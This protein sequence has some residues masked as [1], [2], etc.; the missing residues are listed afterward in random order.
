MKPRLLATDSD[1]LLLG[2]YRSYFP[3]FGFDVAT[4]GDG[5]HCVRLLREFAPDALILGFEL[6]WGGGDGVLSCFREER[7]I[8]LIPVILTSNGLNPAGAGLHLAPPVVTLLEKPFRLRDLRES[9]EAGLR[10]SMVRHGLRATATG[11][12]HDADD[13]L[14]AN[15]SAFHSVSDPQELPHV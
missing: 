14:I 4:A 12:E 8:Q 5:L 15:Q 7:R 9:V 13:G 11:L 6:L 2:I 1:P 3:R 10:G